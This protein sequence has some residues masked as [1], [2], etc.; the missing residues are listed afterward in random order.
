ML[1]PLTSAG[2]CRVGSACDS[3]VLLRTLRSLVVGLCTG[4]QLLN[5]GNLTWETAGHHASQVESWHND[6]L[7]LGPGLELDPRLEHLPSTLP[8]SSFRPCKSSCRRTSHMAGC[9]LSI[10]SL[11]VEDYGSKRTKRL[12]T[13]KVGTLTV[14]AGPTSFLPFDPIGIFIG[15][16]FYLVLSRLTRG[17]IA[18]RIGRRCAHIV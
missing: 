10:I 4:H 11:R 1:V 5:W 18:F 12:T 16:L 15:S 17:H 13:G 9:H 7:L 8:S 6:C 3:V 2:W 14:L